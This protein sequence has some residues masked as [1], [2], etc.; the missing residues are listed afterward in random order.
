LRQF[1]LRSFE[2]IGGK[3]INFWYVSSPFRIQPK[4]LR[5][6]LLLSCRL[7][8][9]LFILSHNIGRAQG[10]KVVVFVNVVERGHELGCKLFKVSSG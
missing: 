3:G 6:I 1:A 4:E 9:A 8:L 10:L 7:A 5:T 2:D